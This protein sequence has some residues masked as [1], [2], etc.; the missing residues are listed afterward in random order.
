MT[1]KQEDYTNEFTQAEIQEEVYIEPPCGFVGAN[2]LYNVIK[3]HTALY[4]LKQ[5][6]KTFVD[7]LKAGLLEQYFI[8]SEI[9]KCMFI[10]GDIVCLVYVDDAILAGP[11]L[12]N[13]NKEI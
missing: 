7:K 1:H 11:N 8:Q 12:K 4:G 6:Q 2:K 10:K 5:A 13:T 3:T 9:D